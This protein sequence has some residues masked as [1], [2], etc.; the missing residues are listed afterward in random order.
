A[1]AP[2]AKLLYCGRCEGVMVST[3]TMRRGEKYR[4]YV[5][6][7]SRLRRAGKCAQRPVAARDLEAAVMRQLEPIVGE[8]LSGPVLQQS[9]D[10]ITYEDSTRR[11]SIMLRDGT[12]VEYTL[13]QPNRPGV[14]GSASEMVAGRVPG[15]R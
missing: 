4:Y 2:V 3:H 14:M 10:R 8:Q 11:I 7:A 12:Q 9:I 15:I 5:C 6:E 13:P 1:V